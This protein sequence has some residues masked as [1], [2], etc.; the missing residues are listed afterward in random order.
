MDWL[1]YKIDTLLYK[2]RH[3][4]NLLKNKMFFSKKSPKMPIFGQKM[5][6]SKLLMPFS[7]YHLLLKN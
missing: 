4:Y 2:N 6:T 7:P 1:E 3:I 5:Y